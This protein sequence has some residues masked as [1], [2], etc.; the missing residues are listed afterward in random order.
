MTMKR[1]LG[2]P[3]R[4]DGR[5]QASGN[6]NFSTYSKPINRADMPVVGGGKALWDFG[7]GFQSFGF[8]KDT[9]EDEH[10]ISPFKPTGE[11]GGPEV[12]RQVA[13]HLFDH[14]KTDQ[15]P[16]VHFSGSYGNQGK[17]YRHVATNIG[18]YAPDY[19]GFEIPSRSDD[20]HHFAVVHKDH[21]PRFQ[22]AMAD[23]MV[24]VKP[25]EPVAKL[26]AMRAPAGGTIVN[27]QF[28]KGGRVIPG[29]LQKIRAVRGRVVQLTRR[30]SGRTYG[31]WT[32]W[33]SGLSHDQAIRVHSALTKKH[34]DHYEFQ[35]KRGDTKAADDVDPFNFGAMNTSQPVGHSVEGR[36]KDIVQLSRLQVNPDAPNRSMDIVPR[37]KT[38]VLTDRQVKNIEDAHGLSPDERLARTV[39]PDG[40]VSASTDAVAQFFDNIG[41][42]RLSHAGVLEKLRDPATEPSEKLA[43]LVNHMTGEASHAKKQAG[44]ALGWYG[45]DIDELDSALTDHF[46]FHGKPHRL[47]LAKAVLAFTSKDQKPVP[48]LMT[49]VRMIEDAHNQ[50]PEQPF[51][52]L[53]PFNYDAMDKWLAGSDE[54]NT[55]GKDIRHVG[56]AEN[57]YDWLKNWG[58]WK[59]KE[60]GYMTAPTIVDKA[61]DRPMGRLSGTSLIPFADFTKDDLKQALAGKTA[62][63]IANTPKVGP[64]GNLLPK[65]W[66]PASSIAGHVEILNR[67]VGE[68][69]EKG[70]ADFLN[71]QHDESALRK[72]KKT[73]DRGDNEKGEKLSGG[74]LFGPKFGPFLENIQ[75]NQDKLTAD[76]WFSRTWNRYLST[77]HD[78]ANG[79][80][81]VPRSGHE[82]KQMRAAAEKAAKKLGLSVAELQATLWFAE[83]SLWRQFGATNESQSFADAARQLR[84]DK[85][86][87]PHQDT[88]FNDRF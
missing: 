87:P 33:H 56:S 35:I 49:A 54:F 30:V 28:Y 48:N 46:G 82:R 36:A 61:T 26:A 12:Y 60:R 59:P 17:L 22:K 76:K 45:K 6:R 2:E 78:A 4:W 88:E 70:A 27:N 51:H 71:G 39:L 44:N 40:Q 62:K 43:H 77:L 31:D 24:H 63:V 29:I 52:H 75:K 72:Y 19:H 83:Q 81:T 42:K 20:E 84:K 67:L 15:P 10:Y 16:A 57:A 47:T 64:D 53:R 79:E 86:M 55:T 23:N 21:L 65:A 13:S 9:T 68:L 85:G 73:V 66:G 3:N 69:G 1:T 41:R 7:P 11:G 38:P 34:G 5:I 18:R 74:Y 8:G 25:L 37:V 80:Q 50:H 58:S 14:L 32:T